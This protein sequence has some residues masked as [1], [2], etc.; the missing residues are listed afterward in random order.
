M[1]KVYINETDLKGYAVK[2]TGLMWT[3]ETDYSAQKA[4]AI[5]KVFNH[6]TREGYDIRELMPQLTLR[7][8][9]TV[10][11]A[12][13][14]TAI[15]EDTINRRR[16]YIDNITFT[17]QD[18]TIELQGS[19]DGTN[20]YTTATLTV[21]STDT[22]KTV[23]IYDSYKYYKLVSTVSTGS[24]D[25]SALLVE[26]IYDELFAYKWLWWIYYDMRKAGD[27]QFDVKMQELERLYDDAFIKTK[28]FLDTDNNEIPD[29]SSEKSNITML[30]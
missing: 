16:L 7:T 30:K 19:N 21:T 25:Y 4:V 26:T 6:F 22:S 3:D 24:L 2:L 11:T 8:S 10:L 23:V 5:D 17:G 28:F 1:L 27:D 20:Y 18:K 12:S 14:T 29:S 15:K 9:G 13:E